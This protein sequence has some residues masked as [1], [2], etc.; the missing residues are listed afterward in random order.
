MHPLRN[1]IAIA[2]F[3][4]GSIASLGLAGQ[5]SAAKGTGTGTGTGT[6]VARGSGTAILDGDIDS[7]ALSGAGGLV[8]VDHA[9]DVT[10]RVSG[11]GARKVSGDTITYVGFNGK[12]TISGSDVTVKLG[13]VN[14]KLAAQGSG[15]FTLQGKGSYDTMPTAAGGEGSWAT[16]GVTGEL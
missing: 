10:V 16:T 14:V 11:R 15:S 8:I 9:G 12:A 2:A 5:A 6:I 3:T 4:V 13:G 7:L 1:A